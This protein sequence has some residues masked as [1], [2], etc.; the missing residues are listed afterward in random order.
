VPKEL[1]AKER[2]IYTA[3]AAE[4]GKPAEIVAK[5]VEGRVNKYLAEVTLLGQPFAKNPDETVE[6]FLKSKGAVVKSFQMYVVGEGIE[7]KTSD[8]A[9]EVAAQAQAAKKDAPEQ[10]A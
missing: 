3:Q 6:K 4:S 7:K 2:E 9:A 10:T 8:F 5:M 1:I